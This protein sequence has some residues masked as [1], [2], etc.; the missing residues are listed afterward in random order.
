MEMKDNSG[1][2][3]FIVNVFAASKKAGKLW[4]QANSILISKGIPYHCRMTGVEGNAHDLTREACAAGY[5]KFIAVGGDGTVHDVLNGIMDH[6][7]GTS[8]DLSEYALGVIPIGSGND[9]IKSLGISKDFSKAIDVIAAG[10]TGKQDVVKVSLMDRSALPDKKVVGTSYMANIGGVG[11]DAR[12]CD[13][14]NSKKT[15]GKRGK[16]L[17]VSALMYN[18]VN[19]VPSRI[20]MFCDGEMLFDGSYLSIA[21]GVGKYSGGGM[22]Q[23]P[24]AVLGDGLVDVTLIPD[25]PISKIAI[26]APKLFTGTFHEVKEL[27]QAQCKSVLILPDEGASEFVEVDGEVVGEAPVLFEVLDQKLDVYIP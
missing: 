9:W 25:L 19:R 18:I 22:R 1:I 17:Y 15:Q 7:I 12:V 2:L 26:E 21:L 8:A 16:M 20:K 4:G 6:V 5:R 11:L 23:T 27:V 10:K 24:K 13:R 3:L 14:V